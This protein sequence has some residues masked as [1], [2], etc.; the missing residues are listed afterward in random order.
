MNS[1]FSA[2]FIYIYMF[3]NVFDVFKELTDTSCFAKEHQELNFPNN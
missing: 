3:F 1:H 2:S